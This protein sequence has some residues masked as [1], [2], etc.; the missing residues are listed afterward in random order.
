MNIQKSRYPWLRQ[1]QE[2]EQQRRADEIAQRRNSLAMMYGAPLSARYGINSGQ[3]QLPGSSQLAGYTGAGPDGVVQPEKPTNLVQ[4][5][6]GPMMLHEGEATIQRPDGGVN[7]IPQDQLQQMEKQKNI[8]GMQEGGTYYPSNRI[9]AMSQFYDQDA[10]KQYD[11]DIKSG[12]A[13]PSDRTVLKTPEQMGQS[14]PT[15]QQT[16]GLGVTDNQAPTQLGTP[17]TPANAASESGI[18]TDL[19]GVQSDINQIQAKPGLQ[20]LQRMA[21]GTDPTMDRIRQEEMARAKGE[22]QAARGALSQTASQLD[23]SPTQYLTE[24]AMLSRQKGSE[25]AQLQSQLR[26]QEQ[27]QRYGATG[28]LA[29]LEATYA[30][31][32]QAKQE[33][34]DSQAW[35]QFE[36]AAKFGDMATVKQAYENV[37]G[38]APENDAQINDII[39]WGRTQREQAAAMGELELEA[40]ELSNLATQFNIDDAQM[41]SVIQAI[42][43]N[44]PLSVVNQQYGTNLTQ[45]QYDDLNETYDLEVQAMGLAVDRGSLENMALQRDMD[46]KTMANVIDSIN[47]GATLATVNDQYGLDLSYNEFYSIQKDYRLNTWAKEVGIRGEELQQEA[48]RYDMTSKEMA[49]IIRDIN[50]GA[51]LQTI[52]STYGKTL[53]TEEYESIRENYEL[54]RQ[55]IQSGIDAQEIKNLAMENNIAA[56][57]MAYIV[58]DIKDGVDIG[59][60]NRSYGTNY[61]YGDFMDLYNRI[62]LADR[63]SELQIEIADIEKQALAH[64][65]DADVMA[66]VI[67]DINNGVS[68]DTVN[69]RYDL[70]GTENELSYGEWNRIRE[71]YSLDVSAKRLG[72]HASLLEYNALENN[73]ATEQ[74]GNIISTIKNGVEDADMLNQKLGLTGSEMLTQSDVDEIVGNLQL[75]EH[76]RAFNV[77]VDDAAYQSLLR[78]VHSGAPLSAVEGE[79]KSVFGEGA[80]AREVW[81]GMYSSSSASLAEQELALEAQRLGYEGRRIRILEDTADAEKYWDQSNRTATFFQTHI[82]EEGESMEQYLDRTGGWEVLQD[83]YTAKTGVVIGTNNAKFRKWAVEE[84]AAAMDNR[85]TNPYDATL[86]QINTSDLPQEAKDVWAS[87][88]QDPDV[89]AQILG[90]EITDDGDVQ[91]QVINE[92]GETETITPTSSPT[93]RSRSFGV[94]GDVETPIDSTSTPDRRGQLYQLGDYNLY[95]NAI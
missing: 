65:L 56:D 57:K 44:T 35:K 74:M 68:V 82:K 67:R 88:L 45:S 33:Y 63:A 46:A 7:V 38:R 84:A 2:S 15:V 78:K 95:G 5:T 3:S 16:G 21:A 18:G 79:I 70:A 86:Y 54:N 12:A 85:L 41:K 37:F 59:T 42:K 29:G 4:T 52:N 60:I 14:T 23:L 92:N 93:R 77:Q 50:Q 51:T 6:K 27:A 61:S 66:S 47:K 89:L 39:E 49:D 40:A 91:V 9:A 24:Q 30:R 8:P 43:N 34:K 58:R 81:N 48:V 73:I 11:T 72:Y 26:Q 32:D 94:P 64:N 87:M 17:T 75:E 36:N 22:E 55:A 69:T 20:G 25:Q 10:L 76:R 71:Q 28:Q 83:W 1:M 62:N 19:S 53:S 80:D 90:L 13:T 31:M